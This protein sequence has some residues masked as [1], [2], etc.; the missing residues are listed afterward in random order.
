MFNSLFSLLSSSLVFLFF[1]S[2]SLS[3]VTCPVFYLWCSFFLLFHVLMCF[4]YFSS[5]SF[6]PFL[7]LWLT[8]SSF[9][10]FISLLRHFRTWLPFHLSITSACSFTFDVLCLFSFMFF[11]LSFFLLLSLHSLFPIPS[12]QLLFFLFFHLDF[13]FK[14]VTIST[15]LCIHVL[16]ASSHSCSLASVFSSSF[17]SFCFSFCYLCLSLFLCVFL[18]SNLSSTTCSSHCAMSIVIF[19]SLPHQH[20]TWLPQPVP[21]PS[22][23]LF[24]FF[25][26]NF[27]YQNWYSSPLLTPFSHPF[28]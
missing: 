28:P 19:S 27:W 23:P 9:F 7:F 25:Y 22:T 14:Y 18:F 21:T 17:P 4:F 6:I 20:V 26:G 5:L 1:Y 11:M 15:P 10:L 3:F 24:L 16:I 13:S 8:F 2:I 12:F